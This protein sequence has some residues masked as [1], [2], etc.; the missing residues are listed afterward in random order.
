LKLRTFDLFESQIIEGPAR[1]H[2]SSFWEESTLF[3][4]HAGVAHFPNMVVG[5]RGVHWPWTMFQ[6]EESSLSLSFRALNGKR[7]L[8]RAEDELM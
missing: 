7:K 5:R 6:W 2:G 8:E 4:L 1:F 3:R